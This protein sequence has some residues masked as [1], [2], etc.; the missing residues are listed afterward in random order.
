M[1]H[2]LVLGKHLGGKSEDPFLRAI[3]INWLSKHD[4][5]PYFPANRRATRTSPPQ[6]HSPLASFSG[7]PRRARDGAKMTMLQKFAARDAAIVAAAAVTWWSVANVS[8][9]SGPLSDLVG[10]IAGLLV[11]ASGFVRQW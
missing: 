2:P 8:A 9:G 7:P 6:P 10:L 5:D 4:A 11:G 1:K 3:S